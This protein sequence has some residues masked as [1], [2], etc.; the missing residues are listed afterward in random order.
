MKLTEVRPIVGN[1]TLR[2]LERDDMNGFNGACSKLCALLYILKTMNKFV[3]VTRGGAPQED[4]SE[5]K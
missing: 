3:G 4:T 1:Y 2:T 5:Y